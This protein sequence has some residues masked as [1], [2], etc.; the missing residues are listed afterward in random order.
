MGKK[1]KDIWDLR[2][3]EIVCFNNKQVLRV[4]DR[5]EKLSRL[6]NLGF[7]TRYNEDNSTSI[8][9]DCMTFENLDWSRK[10]RNLPIIFYD[11]FLEINR[12][13]IK[14]INKQKKDGKK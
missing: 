6:E 1:I 7:K 8:C 4:F 3:Y 14:N 11:K 9:C 10:T 5:L 12:K 2:E 13:L